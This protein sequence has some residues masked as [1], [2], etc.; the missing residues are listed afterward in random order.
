MKGF[1]TKILKLYTKREYT[2]SHD[3]LLPPFPCHVLMTVDYFNQHLYSV[4]Q[5]YQMAVV[6]E[7]WNIY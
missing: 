7:T 6:N 5:N 2:Y 1:P 3:I 4:K